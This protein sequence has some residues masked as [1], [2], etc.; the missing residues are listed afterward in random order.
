[1]LLTTLES[2]PESCWLAATAAPASATPMRCS[3]TR[4]ASAPYVNAVTSEDEAAREPDRRPGDTH[5]PAHRV[6]RPAEQVLKFRRLEALQVDRDDPIEQDG[7]GVPLDDRGQ[8]RLL[9]VL[10][11]T[12][13]A[14]YQAE[15]DHL[16]EQGPDAAEIAS[17]TRGQYR[18]DQ[19]SRDDELR[20][21][22]DG[23]HDLRREA[24]E[25]SAGR[26]L[27]N[28]TERRTEYARHSPKLAPLRRCLDTIA[29]S[30]EDQE[31]R[32]SRAPWGRGSRLA[33]WRGR[34]SFAAHVDK[35]A[36]RRVNYADHNRRTGGAPQYN[37]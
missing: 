26:G 34:N 4:Y 35:G 24:R 17:A 5:H 8:H 33:L 9:L 28:E 15:P 11:Q 13:R 21:R 2:C 27:P 20:A 22:R 3:M 37:A 30:P 1:M 18:S 19:V 23:R 12:G 32:L 29:A 36:F 25:E 6:H 14:R 16:G 10:D 31:I 7:V